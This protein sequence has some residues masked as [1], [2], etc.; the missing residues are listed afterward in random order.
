MLRHAPSEP[1]ERT[2]IPPPVVTR[3]AAASQTNLRS[4]PEA[5]SCRRLDRATR[6]GGA[7]L[8][9]PFSRMQLLSACQGLPW[10]TL[11]SKATSQTL[12]SA[13]ER[14]NVGIVRQHPI[15]RT[16]EGFGCGSRFVCTVV[17]TTEHLRSSYI[18]FGSLS[19]G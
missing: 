9:E 18:L 2:G 3:H 4:D 17:I 11:R 1:A 12:R 7:W 13:S 16:L 8:W 14:L 15:Y 19:P 6:P 10:C 5:L